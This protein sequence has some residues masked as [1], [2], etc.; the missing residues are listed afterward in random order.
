M[1]RAPGS[2]GS[3][4]FAVLRL[5]GDRERAQCPAVERIF[6]GDDF[7]T[8]A[9]DSAFPCERII[10]SAPSMASAPELQKKLRFRPLTFARRSASRPWYS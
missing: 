3:K 9:G 7:C 10:F 8:S 6:E 1:N 5:P 4:V 2:S